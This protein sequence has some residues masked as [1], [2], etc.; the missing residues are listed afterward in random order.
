MNETIPYIAYESSLTRADKT[1]KRLWILNIILMV[2][3]LATNIT[4]IIYENQYIDEISV[5]Q[6][7]DTGDGDAFVNGIGDF[8]YGESKTKGD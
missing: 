5:E 2:L 8:N 6:E 3:L 7:V 4:W 1:N